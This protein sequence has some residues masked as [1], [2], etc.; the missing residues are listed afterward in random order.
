[1]E[2][3]MSTTQAR[4]KPTNLSLDTSL[5]AEAKGL[6]VNL[7]RA[8]EAGLRQ[9]IA[10]AKSERWKAE[11]ADAIDS[12]NQWFETHGLPLDRYRQF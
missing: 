8:A 12:S 7:S 2:D 5:L 10:H 1:M 3:V 9:E 4:K 11:N 6:N